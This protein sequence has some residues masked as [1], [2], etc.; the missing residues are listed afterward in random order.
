MAPRQE[1]AEHV[2]NESLQAVNTAELPTTLAGNVS[3][4]PSG[5][6]GLVA[7][8][9]VLATAFLASM[10][11]FSFGYDQGV[12]SIINVMPQFHR[13]YP[14][15]DP[16][17]PGSDFNLSVMTAMLTLGAFV[18]C[19]FM[20]WLCD[21]ISRKY[22]LSVVAAIFNVG[23]IVQTAAPNYATLV[24]GR[25]LGGVGTGTL[26]LGAPIYISEIAPPNL[27]GALLVLQSIS[28]V[29]GVLVAYWLTYGT[30]YIDSE[31]SFRLPFGLS[32]VSAI[33]LG[34]AILFFPFSPRWLVLLDRNEEALKSLAKL[35]RLPTDDPRVQTEWQGIMAEI[36]FQKAVQE[37][38][39]PGKTGFRLEVLE[40]LDLFK[41]KTWRRT[42][43]GTGVAFFQQFSGINA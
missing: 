16:D 3:Y 37:K 29:F 28:I 18:G 27:R 12:I 41:K 4:G 43:V 36:E 20:P 25:A 31:L 10:G 35:R 42:V 15:V 7:S 39:H 21:R 11:G 22:A 19:F 14:E 33:I 32:M 40:W 38:A 24:F 34:I 5:V 6:K 9:Y 8:P 26:A 23:T 30:R 1:Y 2:E 17:T 13:A